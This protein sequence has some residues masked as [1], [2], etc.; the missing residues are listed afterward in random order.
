MTTLNAAEIKTT[1]LLSIYEVTHDELLFH[2]FRSA[3]ADGCA[4]MIW[5]VIL[6][7]LQKGLL[8]YFHT[9]VEGGHQRIGERISG[10]DPNF[11]GEVCTKAYRGTSAKHG[12]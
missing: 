5:L 7:L 2:D 4:N 10:S 3:P 1:A 12:L 9:S 6:E 11:I 8:P